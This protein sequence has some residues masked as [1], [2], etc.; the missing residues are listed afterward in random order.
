MGVWG[1]FKVEMLKVIQLLSFKETNK[2]NLICVCIYPRTKIL[3]TPLRKPVPRGLD[4]RQ[5]WV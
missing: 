1:G 3:W 2:E 4:T 5:W